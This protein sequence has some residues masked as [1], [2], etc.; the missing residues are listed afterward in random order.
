MYSVN[1]IQLAKELSFEKQ[2]LVKNYK[3]L[4]LNNLKILFLCTFEN[5]KNNI[6]NKYIFKLKNGCKPDR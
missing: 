5:L 1:N 3:K 4:T 2:K 6:L